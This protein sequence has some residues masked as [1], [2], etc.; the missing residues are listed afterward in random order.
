MST[1]QGSVPTGTK[2]S[3]EMAEYVKEESNR[4]GVTKAEFHR[5]LLDLYKSSRESEKDCPHCDEPI[6]L[7]L[8]GSDE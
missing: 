2:V 6:V 7:D 8:R 4:L 5:R 1:C 3:V